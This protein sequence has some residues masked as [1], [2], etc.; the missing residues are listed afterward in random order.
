MKKKKQSQT[1]CHIKF[2]FESLDEF[3]A[4]NLNKTSQ[5]VLKLYFNL[6]E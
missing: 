3:E 5:K 1:W 2:T 6:D 4:I